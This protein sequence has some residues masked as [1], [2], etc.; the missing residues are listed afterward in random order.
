[1]VD[2]SGEERHLI[3]YF[4]SMGA[5]KLGLLFFNA[6]ML[7]P[8]VLFA[9]YGLYRQDVIAL[10]VAFF[11]LLIYQTWR[12]SRELKHSKTFTSICKKLEIRSMETENLH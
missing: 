11:G 7:V 10:A 9:V 3:S 5:D 12:I 4:A 8:F 1:M 2:F 6:A